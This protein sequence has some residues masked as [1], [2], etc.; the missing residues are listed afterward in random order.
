MRQV[1]E[2]CGRSYSDNRGSTVC[3]HRAILKQQKGGISGSS[4][5]APRGL[6]GDE[7]AM[8]DR[9]NRQEALD[10]EADLAGITHFEDL[11]RVR[12][13]EQ[14]LEEA[15][16]LSQISR[17]ILAQKKIDQYRFKHGI[18]HEVRR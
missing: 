14:R 7:Q 2:K 8:I 17:L 18:E 5:D 13:L 11:E 12:E 16:A 15:K 9:A 10:R 4:L 3:P 1:C 6:T